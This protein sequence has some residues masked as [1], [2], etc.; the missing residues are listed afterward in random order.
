MFSRKMCKMFNLKKSVNFLSIFHKKFVN[1]DKLLENNHYDHDKMPSLFSETFQQSSNQLVDLIEKQ[2]S[3]M[4]KEDLKIQLEKEFLENK[5]K[6]FELSRET[7]V[8]FLQKGMLGDANKFILNQTEVILVGTI[9]NRIPIE[10]LYK[11]L[12]YVKP[13]IILIQQRPDRMLGGIYENIVNLNKKLIDENKF[14]EKLIRDP[15]EIQTSLKNKESIKERLFKKGILLNLKKREKEREVIE[16][17][18]ENFKNISEHER[19]T[20][21]SQSLISLWGEQKDVKILVSDFPEVSLYEKLSNSLTLVQLR[22]TFESIFTE[23]PNNPDFEPSTPIG[24]AINLY[25]DLF[26]TNS[27]AYI[28]QIIYSLT[29]KEE[30]KNKKIISFL[31]YGQSYTIPLFLNYERDRNSLSKILTPIKRYSS[32]LYGD[33]SLEVLV[34]K[35]AMISLILNGL[36]KYDTYLEIPIEEFQNNE[37]NELQNLSLNSIE[38]QSKSSFDQYMSKHRNILSSQKLKVQK[39]NIEKYNYD[40]LFGDDK[41]I[42]HLSR[43]YA[44][45]DLIKT[46]FNSEKFLINRMKYLYDCIIKE[47]RKEALCLI[48]IGYEKKKKGFMRRIIDDPLLSA[49][50]MK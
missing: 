26:V 42:D 14:I 22:K 17:T 39:D 47:K 10:N 18:Q 8:E 2:I 21:D 19:L 27:D 43:K 25:P 44:R 31:G 7:Y 50:I 23:F 1:S 12:N 16:K 36:E 35:W 11:L 13:D 34:E 28:S 32:L 3:E 6:T 40:S 48:K 20:N 41:I 30:L 37:K 24:T 4:R 49:E 9:Y 33:D 38:N 5:D 46:G 45:D 29:K 15:W